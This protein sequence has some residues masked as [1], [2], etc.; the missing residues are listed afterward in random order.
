MFDD[1]DDDIEKR[2]NLAPHN[3]VSL[4]LIVRPSM[5]PFG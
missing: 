1:H 4:V 2:N 5:T 3:F